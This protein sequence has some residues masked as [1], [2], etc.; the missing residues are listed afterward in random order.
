M[1]SKRTGRRG[2]RHVCSKTL[3][4]RVAMAITHTNM[5][6]HQTKQ[7]TSRLKCRLSFQITHQVSPSFSSHLYVE[8][9]PPL[10]AKIQNELPE[11]THPFH[12]SQT[13]I[14]DGF[15]F[16][17]N[18]MPTASQL[19]LDGSAESGPYLHNN[20]ININPLRRKFPL[21]SFWNCNCK[22]AARFRIKR[23]SISTW[24]VAFRRQERE[25]E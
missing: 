17:T 18:T 3:T 23:E 20:V 2:P 10:D 15:S 7:L 25:I 21:F 6:I 4:S 11:R 9:G 12:M 16:D 5:L 13:A 22:D 24:R 14:I 19:D 1:P 8:I